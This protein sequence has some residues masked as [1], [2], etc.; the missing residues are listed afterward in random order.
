MK[1]ILTLVA[2]EIPEH[3]SIH[4]TA[5]YLDSLEDMRWIGKL[6]GFS[7]I[8]ATVFKSSPHEF[9]FIVHFPIYVQL[10]NKV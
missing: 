5:I 2:I 7:Y 4:V 8:F 3:A 1:E 9:T 6:T 10:V